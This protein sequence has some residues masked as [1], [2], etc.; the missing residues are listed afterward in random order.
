MTTTDLS[1]IRTVLADGRARFDAAWRAFDLIRDKLSV[2]PAT[3]GRWVVFDGAVVHHVA[4]DKRAA[5]R[6]GMLHLGPTCGFI[7]AFCGSKR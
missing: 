4:T 1:E 3:A 7:V 6:W 2:Y 5:H